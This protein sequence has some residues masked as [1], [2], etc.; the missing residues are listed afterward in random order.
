MDIVL[1]CIGI[2]L[3][4]PV[5][6]AILI[7]YFFRWEK[8]FFSQQRPGKNEKLFTLIKFKTMRS[9]TDKDTEPHSPNRITVWGKFLRKTSLDETPQ[10]LNV[11]LGDMSIVGPRPLLVEYLPLYSQEQRK[12]HLVKPG[13]TGYA[14]IMGRNAISWAQKFHFD[15][16]Y[17]QHISFWLDLKILILTPFALSYSEPPEPFNG[18]N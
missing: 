16:Y 18:H 14:Q 8:P 17:V 4:L 6:T 15:L 9:L 12:R 13:I 5:W 11:L 3:M 2:I 7:I 10:L 1:A